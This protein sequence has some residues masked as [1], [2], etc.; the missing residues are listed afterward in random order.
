MEH[1]PDLFYDLALILVTAGITTVLFK[2]MK[3]PLVLGYIVAGFLIGPYFEYFPVVI[4]SR[5]V[6]VWSEIGMVFLLF[7]L[8][9]EFSFKKLKKVGGPGAITA[10]TEL[11]VMFVVGATLGKVL[12]W[13]RMNSIFLGCMLSISS[14]TIIVK[15]FDDLK[16]KRHKFSGSVIGVLVVEDLIAVMLLV[17]LST[18]SVSKQFDGMELGFSMLKLAFFLIV[19]FVFGIFLIPSFLRLMRKAMTEETLVI[20]AV[21][22]CFLMV[23]MAN[24]AG[25]SSALG[26]FIMGSILAETLEAEAIHKLINPVKNL[27]GAV[28]FVSVGMMVNPNILVRYALP[29]LLIAL[30][31]VVMKSISATMGML[32]SGKDIKTSFQ[33]GF[34]FCQIGEFSF[35]IATLGM[36]YGVIDEFLYPII[37]TVSI[38]TTFVT[39]YMMRL[40]LPLYERLL[41][42]I[43][44]RLQLALK[45]YAEKGRFVEDSFNIKKFV[46]MQL[47][48]SVLYLAII[49]ALILISFTLL[50]PF[51]RASIDGIWADVLGVA[52]TLLVMAPFLWALAFKSYTRREV[53][54]IFSDNK[55]HHGVFLSVLILKNVVALAAVGF[56]IGNY[57][58]VTYAFIL[59]FLTFLVMF[60]VFFRQVTRFYARIEKRFMDNLNQRQSQNSF[61]IPAFLEQNFCL[62]K[63]V[64][65]SDSIYAGKRLGDTDFRDKYNSSVVTVE[66]GTQVFDLPK[67]DFQ[68]FPHDVLTMVAREDQMREL[69]HQLD[70]DEEQLVRERPRSDM[71]LYKMVMTPHNPFYGMS[72]RESYNAMV[73]A[74]ERDGD[75]MLNPSA[76][77]VFET[78]DV[79]WYVCDEV[80]AKKLLDYE[81]QQHAINRPFILH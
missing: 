31:V 57:I 30:A 46:L 50:K 29:V 26:A 15:A 7:A 40:A 56:V 62:E 55:L 16:L 33:A 77:I 68:I 49:I 48:N 59:I 39:P 73:I 20:V 10:I 6:E 42:H 28:F 80:S 12:G 34:C 63:I 36:S 54:R 72:L 24:Y 79:I 14:T 1:L 43:P 41:P 27:F 44:Q 60:F 37:V 81:S 45:Q 75:F 51:L 71:D 47:K 67:K 5:S 19:W 18:L 78:D 23:V 66:R 13:S 17:V 2:W 9:L 53:W 21:G 69:K 52:I 8:G 76:S 35:I 70:T 3:Q 74:I 22:L 65:S 25:F 58:S 4:D 32:L 61:V 11:V 64:V 38:I